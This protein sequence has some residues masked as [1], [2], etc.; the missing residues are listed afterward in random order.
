MSEDSFDRHN[1]GGTTG[2]QWAEARVAAEYHMRHRRALFNVAL[3]G[4]KCQ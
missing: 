4:T 2:I 1:L 3:S